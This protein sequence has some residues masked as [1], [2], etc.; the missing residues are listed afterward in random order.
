MQMKK[1]LLCI[2]TICVVFV[3][4]LGISAYADEP[5]PFALDHCGT[6]RVVE[7]TSL[8]NE[9]LV[10]I[11]IC[12]CLRGVA[13]DG[14]LYSYTRVTIQKCTGCGTILSRTETPYNRWA[15]PYGYF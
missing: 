11:G 6:G 9:T 7:N 1:K 15:C 14:G 10:R 2:F 5:Q 3:G 8:I 12:P 13:H 4:L